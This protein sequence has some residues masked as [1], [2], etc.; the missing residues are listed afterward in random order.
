M[1]HGFR[2][3]WP[4]A[5]QRQ[6]Q[7]RALNPRHPQARAYV[8]CVHGESEKKRNPCNGAI[9]SVAALCLLPDHSKAHRERKTRLL[10]ARDFSPIK[11]RRKCLLLLTRTRLA[12]CLSLLA[13]CDLKLSNRLMCADDKRHV[14]EGQK[15]RSIN[16]PQVAKMVVGCCCLAV[17]AY[18]SAQQ[19]LHAMLHATYLV[20]IQKTERELL[21]GVAEKGEWNPAAAGD[22]AVVADKYILT[23]YTGM[24]P[25]CQQRK[26]WHIRCRTCVGLAAGCKTI[27]FQH[28]SAYICAQQC[29]SFLQ[30]TCIHTHTHS[31]LHIL[32]HLSKCM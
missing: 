18:C 10:V 5:Q 2:A 20:L 25:N 27:P 16:S 26:L 31:A 4:N 17:L 29:I 15:G 6:P 12:C 1:Q 9:N 13:C 14:R 19:Y 7:Q 23:L 22:A 32:A 8:M 3:I 21:R 30:S 24:H 28:S 11:D